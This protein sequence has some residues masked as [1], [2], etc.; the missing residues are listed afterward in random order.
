M[1]ITFFGGEYEVNFDNNGGTGGAESEYPPVTSPLVICAHLGDNVPPYL[2]GIVTPPTKAG[3]V[4]EG[5]FNDLSG[6]DVMYYDAIGVR[7]N[8][9][10]FWITPVTLKARWTQVDF[11]VTYQLDGGS[12]VLNRSTPDGPYAYNA[13][14]TVDAVTS[15]T[16]AN[17]TFDGW[18]DQNG[19][20]YAEG[21]KFNIKED[22]T[23]TAVWACKV[24]YDPNGGTGASIVDLTLYAPGSSVTL[25]WAGG[26]TPPTTPTPHMIFTGWVDASTSTKYQA[27][28]VITISQNMLL[29]AE[30]TPS[31]TVT[32]LFGTSDS[33]T[34]PVDIYS[35]YAEGATVKV[36]GAG[37][38]T[39][40]GKI[41]LGWE[42]SSL[43]YKSNQTFEI[44]KDMEFTPIWGDPPTIPV[45][46]VF[47][48]LN[49]TYNVGESMD[50]TIV[51]GWEMDLTVF[52]VNGAKLSAGITTF[53]PAAKGTYL[54]EA[55]T[56]DGAIRIWKYVKVN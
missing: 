53:V 30:W 32:Y 9:W 15:L 25:Q 35:P 40:A 10:N 34:I 44:N 7:A 21:S 14:V 48:N 16:K 41:F 29:Q 23:L 47:N 3:Y 36:K 46:P 8:D 6:T 42:D 54:I 45:I 2:P 28:Q 39:K 19:I 11:Y 27:G 38:L 1:Y 12:G 55:E 49:D 13:E 17:Y 33:G 24:T 5:Y 37:T 4:F 22:M 52:Y 51:Y 26:L 20:R 18:K 56:P 50:L 31:Y 43:E